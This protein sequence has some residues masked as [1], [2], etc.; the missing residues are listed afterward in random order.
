MI[1]GDL[2]MLNPEQRAIVF[3]EPRW[4]MR[5]LASQLNWN[6]LEL[7]WVRFTDED[8]LL[9]KRVPDSRILI[10]YVTMDK[11]FHIQINK[12]HDYPG[13][14]QA[15]VGPFRYRI[16]QV[17]IGWHRFE[18]FDEDDRIKEELRRLKP[19]LDRQLFRDPWRR[20][21]WK[22]AHPEFDFER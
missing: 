8:A 17:K 18:L 9:D 2:G 13:L 11:E 3:A 16:S 22:K 1:N 7:E 20:A 15:T 4:R 21:A 12:I 5:W 10:Y 19:H 6:G 14:Y